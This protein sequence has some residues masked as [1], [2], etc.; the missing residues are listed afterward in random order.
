MLGLL[1]LLELFEANSYEITQILNK[2]WFLMAIGALLVA[3]VPLL[4][5]IAQHGKVR[6]G[7]DSLRVP[8][9]YFAHFY[10]LSTTLFLITI[11]IDHLWMRYDVVKF[12]FLFHSLRRV[13]ECLFVFEFGDSSMH[14]CGY[15][16]GILHYLLVFVTLEVSCLERRLLSEQ[17]RWNVVRSAAV[18][19]FC[20]VNYLQ[21]HCHTILSRQKRRGLKDGG[22]AVYRL[23]REGLF[24]YCCCPHY[25]AEVLLYLS[26][27]IV[28]SHCLTAMLM[29]VWVLVNLSVVAY[30]QY[31]WY[32]ENDFVAMSERNVK[33]L[34]PLLW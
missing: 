20:A 17:W 32:L 3:F 13:Y 2:L 26:I 18:A 27:A 15:L 28:E 4:R 31:Q 22:N 33:I 10:Y 7:S 14:I 5:D 8:K 16:C 24:N 25:F 12:M 30:E 11:W 1:E 34:I 21:F 23:P 19:L 9:K 29:A 6:T